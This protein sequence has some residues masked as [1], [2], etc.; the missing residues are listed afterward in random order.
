MGCGGIA[1]HAVAMGG[2]QEFAG[3]LLGAIRRDGRGM[4]ADRMGAATVQVV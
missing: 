2:G 4:G 1:V 3:C